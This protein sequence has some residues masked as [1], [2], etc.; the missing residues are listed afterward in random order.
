MAPYDA[1]IVSVGC[2]VDSLNNSAS[3]GHSCTKLLG[4]ENPPTGL[5]SYFYFCVLFIFLFLIFFSFSE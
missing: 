4:G 3:Y 5:L 1:Y 2:W